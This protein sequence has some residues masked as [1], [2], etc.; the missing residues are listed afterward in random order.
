MTRSRCKA[1]LAAIS[2]LALV[3]G[4]AIGSAAPASATT[5][6]NLA[7]V[8]TGTGPSTFTLPTTDGFNDKRTFEVTAA[9]KVDVVVELIDPIDS[10]HIVKTVSA[11]SLA[12]SGTHYAKKVTIADSGLG[13]GGVHIV[14]Q[15]KN[16]TGP[17]DTS[18]AV[19][20]QVGSGKAVDVA[21]SSLL[22]A[23]PDAVSPWNTV[24]A[25]LAATD[26]TLTPLPLHN[27]TLTVTNGS[28]TATSAVGSNPLSSSGAISLKRS[29]TIPVDFPIGTASIT[30]SVSGPADGSVTH[31][32]A[33]TVPIALTKLWSIAVSSS[34]PTVYPHHDGYRDSTTITVTPSAADVESAPV[35][36]SVRI[37][38]AGKVVKTWKLKNSNVVHFSWNGL[39]A[40]KIRPGTYQILVTGSQ[41]D[42]DTPVTA[43]TTI[44]VSAAQ[45]HTH[46]IVLKQDAADVLTDFA[47]QSGG[48]LTP[49]TL[50]ACNAEAT[51]AV[52]CVGQ[53]ID[54]APGFV[55]IKAE[56]GEESLPTSVAAAESAG[57]APV[58]AKVVADVS[59]LAG[60]TTYLVET[61]LAQPFSQVTGTLKKGDHTLGAVSFGTPAEELGAD[62]Y[63]FA[64]S[65]EGSA[66]FRVTSFVTTFTYKTLS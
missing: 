48:N 20:W 14:A 4:I 13:E 51:G 42:N 44:A 55:S 65:V 58:T 63:D 33:G 61:G 18:A 43:S 60:T 54:T 15:V 12:K 5:P 46:T 50:P 49:G 37:V 19:S 62:E 22:A 3:V 57:V 34:L 26:E 45:I 29:V 6:L 32:Q 35:T 36:G 10:T 30:A 21:I 16:S 9:R 64:F 28:H 25:T 31:T 11:G 41:P 7:I 66:E 1:L 52:T 23:F 2:T 40:G 24:R 8:A 17:A 56:S 27:A 39:I 47:A 53:M 38:L 59:S